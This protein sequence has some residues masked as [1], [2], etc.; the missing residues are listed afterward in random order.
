M[1]DDGK[2]DV[3]KAGFVVYDTVSKCYRA[4]GDSLG[5]VR[6]IGRKFE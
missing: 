4:V 3:T 1:T 5:P 2:V 6:S